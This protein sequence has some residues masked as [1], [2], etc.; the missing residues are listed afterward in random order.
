MSAL[1]VKNHVSLKMVLG[2]SVILKTTSQL[3]SQGYRRLLRQARLVQHL[4]HQYRRQV[5]VSIECESADEQGRGNPSTLDNKVRG[6][7]CS[8]EI[9]E[10]LQEFKGNLVD[11]RVPEHGDSHASTSHEPSSEPQRREVPG[12]Q[13]LHTFP[14]RPKLRNLPEASNCKGPV[15][16]TQ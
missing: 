10:R 1:V 12:N 3:W 16:K 13:C 15:Q 4:Q 8:S 2:F 9:P 7:P 6:N 5:K 14:E 11:E